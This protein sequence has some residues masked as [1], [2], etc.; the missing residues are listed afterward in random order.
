MLCGASL[1]RISTSWQQHRRRFRKI[2]FV[3]Q[4]F[5]LS[6]SPARSV[7]SRHDEWRRDDDVEN[8]FF[9][10]VSHNIILTD[11]T[12]YWHS[13]NPV[14]LEERFIIAMYN[15]WQ[16]DWFRRLIKKLTHNIFI[17]AVVFCVENVLMYFEMLFRWFINVLFFFNCKPRLYVQIWLKYNST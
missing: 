13:R 11:Y 10:R 8:I 5:S 2:H 17:L 15:K 12:V 6:L 16:D 4:F 14:P 7:V 9:K 3:S 1:C